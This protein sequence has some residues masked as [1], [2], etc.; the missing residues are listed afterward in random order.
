MV[1]ESVRGSARMDLESRTFHDLLW[2][3]LK[4]MMP[5]SGSLESVMYAYLREHQLVD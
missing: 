3:R 4:T 2:A 1:T 5:G